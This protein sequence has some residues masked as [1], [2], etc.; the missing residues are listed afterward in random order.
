MF[1]DTDNKDN[2]SEI[3]SQPA[4]PSSDN[5]A[6]T[7][8]NKKAGYAQ[9][10]SARDLGNELEINFDEDD[11]PTKTA[12]KTTRKSFGVNYITAAPAPSSAPLSLMLDSDTD[13]LA[14]LDCFYRRLFPFRE[15]Y[16]W[17]S[18]GLVQRNYFQNRELSF[19]LASDSYLRFQ[20]FKDGE[21]LKHRILELKPVKI[22]IGAVYNAKPKEKKSIQEG[23]FN[24]L[25]RELVFD[26]DMTDYDPIRGA[27]ICLKCWD[28]MTVSIKILDRALEAE[29]NKK[30]FH[31]AEDF[32]FKHRLW[33]YSGRRGV[34]CWVCDDRARKLNVEARRAIVSYLEVVKGG[35]ENSK[36][37]SLSSKSTHPAIREAEK[38]LGPIFTT[39]LINNQDILTSP[40]KYEK[41]LQ[42]IPD[43]ELKKRLRSSW[44]NK[45]KR[46]V[47][48][49]SEIMGETQALS[50]KKPALAATLQEILFNYS[51]PRLDSNVSIGLNHLLKAPFCVHPKTGRVCIPIDQ[52]Y[53]DSFNPFQAPKVF[54]LI[55]EISAYDSAH[56]GGPSVPG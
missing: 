51:Y 20:S 21:E 38:I 28:F 41:L 54:D 5:D 16:R 48:K 29:K 14:L 35:D 4:S 46:P 39:R 50:K 30:D 27:D 56:V 43:E 3:L 53:C 6:T 31:R 18:Y 11:L 49:W 7:G 52:K 19:T 34:H 44:E 10:Q 24:A 47:E 45:N 55:N 2:R 42:L 8:K 15:F 17:L 25:E 40:E 9:P 37:V 22:D 12:T 1:S 26:I 33:V 32:G 13:F 23:R 36:K